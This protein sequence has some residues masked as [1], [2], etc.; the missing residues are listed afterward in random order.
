MLRRTAPRQ[1][2][3]PL[4]DHQSSGRSDAHGATAEDSAFVAQIASEL[5]AGTHLSLGMDG[6][7]G[8]AGLLVKPQML[9]LFLSCM[10]Q[11]RPRGPH[12]GGDGNDHTQTHRRRAVDAKSRYSGTSPSQKRFDN[13]V[14]PCTWGWLSVVCGHCV[15]PV[16]AVCQSQ[17]LP[18]AVDAIA[19][20]VPPV[21]TLDPNFRPPSANF[22]PQL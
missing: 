18:H 10:A 5:A 11:S 4:L 14:C 16:D 2:W 13:N 12:I 1:Q 19:V 21:P 6:L 8:R 9:L 22:R 20:V 17:T 7:G 15:P 3:Q